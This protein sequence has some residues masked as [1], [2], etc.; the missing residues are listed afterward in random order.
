MLENKPW[1][2]PKAYSSKANH[3]NNFFQEN[4]PDLFKTWEGIRKIIN[5]AIKG[6]KEINC[7]QVGNKTI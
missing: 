5:L 3:F 1:V 4:K 7:I 2:K 6:S